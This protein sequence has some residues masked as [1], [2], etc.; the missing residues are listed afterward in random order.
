MVDDGCVLVVPDD[1]AIYMRRNNMLNGLFLFRRPTQNSPRPTPRS[2]LPTTA[3]RSPCVISSFRSLSS[4]M[5]DLMLQADKINTLTTAAGVEVEPIWAT[6]LA[7]ALEG[8]NVKDLL[9]NVGSGGGG[10]PVAAGGVPAASGGAPAAEAEAEKPKEEEKEES[11]DDMV[12]SFV[13]AAAEHELTISRGSVCSTE[14]MR[15]PSLCIFYCRVALLAMYSS[16]LRN[17]C[18]S[19][20]LIFFAASSHEISVYSYTATFHDFVMSAQHACC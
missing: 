16:S 20:D 4:F 1:S 10:A 7:K 3:L 9:A 2:S 18:P 5:I 8:K 6:L 19:F 13:V 11:D 12:R 15:S 17:T 14:C